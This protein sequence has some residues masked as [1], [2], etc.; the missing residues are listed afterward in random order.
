MPRSATTQTRSIAK[1][2]DHGDQGG[3]IRGVARPHLGAELPTLGIDHHG[4]DHLL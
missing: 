2:V 4:E 1:R 3:Y